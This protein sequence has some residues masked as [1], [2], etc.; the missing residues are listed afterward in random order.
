M[1]STCGQFVF[2]LLFVNMGTSY[3]GKASHRLAGGRPVRPVSPVTKEPPSCLPHLLVYFGHK[4]EKPCTLM[5]S[6][7]K[8]LHGNQ[9]NNE[10]L[11]SLSQYSFQN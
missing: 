1:K 2:F 8:N 11:V 5:Y 10:G 4:S 9:H 6:Q 7:L 3:D